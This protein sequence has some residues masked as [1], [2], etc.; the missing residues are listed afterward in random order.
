MPAEKI[1]RAATDLKQTG[2]D[3]GGPY[4]EPEAYKG[5]CARTMFDRPGA[6]DGTITVLVP[7][8][9]IGTVKRDAYVRIPSIHPRTREIEAEYLGVV[10]SGPFAEPDALAATAPT[11]VVAAAHGAV[12]TP[13]YHGIA[14]VEVFGER[15]QG[16][17][18][19]PVSRPCP[20]SPVF[21]LEDDDVEKV[22]GLDLPA[23]DKPFRLGLLDGGSSLAVKVP[24]ARKSGL[25]KHLAI[26]G[27]TGGGK[28]TT[29]SGTM[30]NLAR[31]GNAVVVFDI[32]GEYTTMNQPTENP[33]MKAAL[34]KRRQAPAGAPNTT[35]FCLTDRSPSNPAH[36]DI[37]YFKIAF[38]ELS[39][40]VLTEVLDLSE[41][42]VRWPRLFGQF[43][44]FDEWSLCR[45]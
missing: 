11:L 35:L 3:N 23:D 13:K 41:P 42:Q 9:Q 8:H 19:P 21:L 16:S 2:I 24:A 37:C 30:M 33:Q 20:N 40:Y 7:E 10:A 14:Q 26:L 38:D 6:E 15:V 39:P 25:F 45:G 12:L 44:R 17:L 4:Q 1:A 5:S 31:A 43:F 34:T 18:I 27:T 36:P 28:S 32:E 22:L 29:V